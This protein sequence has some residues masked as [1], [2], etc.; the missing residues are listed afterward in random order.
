[1]GKRDEKVL[2]KKGKR[3]IKTGG[4]GGSQGKPAP[5]RVG[6]ACTGTAAEDKRPG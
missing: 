1:M 3:M 5:Y 4:W 2:R 6:H